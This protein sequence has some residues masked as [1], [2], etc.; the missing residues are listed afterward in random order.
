M[1]SK[2]K[3]SLSV[4]IAEEFG[5]KE[6]ASISLEAL[7]ELAR[8]AGYDALCMRASQVGVQSPV[9]AVDRA[10]AILEESGLTVT[11]VTG[12]FDLVYNNDQGPEVLARIEAHL[13]LAR[14][15]K[16]RMVRVALK[17]DD[18]VEAARAAADRAAADGIT[19]V[20]QCHTQ[21]LFETVEGIERTLRRIDRP[22]FGLIYEPANLE[23]CGQEYGREVIERLAPWIRNVYLQNQKLKPDGKI[24]LK[25]WNCGPVAFD[26]IPI[27]SGG[28]IRFEE[29]FAGL[30][31]IGYRG[32]ITVHQAGMDG[33]SPAETA[34]ATAQYLRGLMSGRFD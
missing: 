17:R 24:V 29:V 23:L 16:A 8:E 7:A 9:G 32:P 33:E 3:L 18:Q 4:R 6:R 15:L 1:P 13:E 25:T 2:M 30:S 34:R 12:N 5:S 19:L 26:L 14:R 10:R 22:N 21:S 31:A 28:G 27:H 20:H 11:M